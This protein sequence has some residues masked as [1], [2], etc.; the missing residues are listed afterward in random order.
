M[1]SI[2]TPANPDRDDRDSDER[3]LHAALELFGQNGFDGTSVRAIAAQ[4]EVSAAL[5]I[6]H[7]GSKEGLRAECDTFV[8]ERLT[9]DRSEMENPA[10]VQEGIEAWLREPTRYRVLLDYTARMLLD[11]GEA[12]TALFD[13]MFQ[14]TRTLVTEYA[15]GGLMRPVEDPDMV[16]MLLTTQGLSTL[17]F[18]RHIARAFAGTAGG[19]PD[20]GS[21]DGD[22]DEGL[23]PEILRRMVLPTIDLY[24]HGLYRDDSILTATR[25]ALS[26]AAGEAEPG[27]PEQATGPPGP[28]HAS[29]TPPHSARPA[30]TP[31]ETS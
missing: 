24:T 29:V 25:A 2:G 15:A 4:A 7:F 23:T 28:G 3:I 21:G 8:S 6:H 17:V 22:G 13:R 31:E 5:I 10:R 12:G 20:S 19:G 1:R 11:G 30:P 18:Q 16:A 14:D 9:R 26:G 27:T